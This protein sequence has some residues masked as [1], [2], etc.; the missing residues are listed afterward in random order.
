MCEE[1]GKD[2]API[3]MQN[4]FALLALSI[5]GEEERNLFG[6]SLQKKTG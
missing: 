2:L 4:N 3:C 5:T 6:N 1:K